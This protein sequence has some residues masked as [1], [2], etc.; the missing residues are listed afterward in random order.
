MTTSAEAAL[1]L[2]IE[3]VGEYSDIFES[4][5]L[6]GD[7]NNDGIPNL[8]AYALSATSPS[9]PAFSPTL[10]LFASDLSI[11]AVIRIN[12]PKLTVV[13]QVIAELL[14][15]SNSSQILTIN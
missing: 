13:G 3:N 7:S 4:Y 12:D 14:D 15:Y 2:N 9:S 10:S 8:L 6:E 11:T 5:P 1:F